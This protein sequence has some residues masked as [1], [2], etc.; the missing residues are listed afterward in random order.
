MTN[1]TKQ[2]NEVK[3]IS[4]DSQNLDRQRVRDKSPFRFKHLLILL[5]LFISMSMN[6]QKNIA[7]L[8]TVTG[9]GNN[10]PGCQ[11]GACAT[12]NDL[13]FG[14]CGT[15]IVWI[16]TGSPPSQIAGVDFIQFDFP[17]VKRF[18]KIIIHH[19]SNLDARFLA[20]GTI[21]YYNGSTWVPHHK[22]ANLP[23]N[24]SSTISFNALST[25]KFRITWKSVQ[26]TINE[27]G[28]DAGEFQMQVRI[29]AFGGNGKSILDVDKKNGALEAWDKLDTNLKKMM[30]IQAPWTFLKGSSSNPLVLKEK[31]MWNSNQSVV[32]N[33][34]K[35]AMDGRIGIT[36]DAVEFD[37]F[38][39]DY[40]DS[41]TWVKKI[42]EITKLT[43]VVLVINEG[44]ARLT[45][46][47]DVE[48]LY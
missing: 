27:D 47:F 32:F 36:V 34:P 10:A 5:V 21:E 6:A 9:Q 2:K 13:N 48:P 40:Y 31:E 26:N 22:F 4:L 8:A 14:V 18:N 11:S 16:S 25:N 45:F 12:F 41:N 24:C 19:A 28:N 3:I 42:K 30:N 17:S 46:I 7:P 39:D 33:I 23:L 37:D 35:D 43:P 15:Q 29:R 20:G 1:F 38:T 44:G